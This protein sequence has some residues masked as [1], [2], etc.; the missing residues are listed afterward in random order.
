M[1]ACE[2]CECL[3]QQFCILASKPICEFSV[4]HSSSLSLTPHTHTH[5]ASRLVKHTGYG[6]AAGLLLSH[7]L[8][9][10]VKSEGEDEYS[11]DSETS[12]TEEYE[13]SKPQ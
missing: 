13:H 4:I 3:Y 9:G 5:T 2:G 1:C 11:T 10:G 7:G 12:D 8:L 6:N